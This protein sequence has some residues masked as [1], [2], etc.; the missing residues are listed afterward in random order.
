MKIGKQQ[1]CEA[2]NFTYRLPFQHMWIKFDPIFFFFFCRHLRILISP[3]HLICLF[4]LVQV[5]CKVNGATATSMSRISK[6]CGRDSTENS[7]ADIQNPVSL[8]EDPL[9]LLVD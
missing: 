9:V 8:P 7:T 6:H 3:S 2:E 1:R 5:W 4:D